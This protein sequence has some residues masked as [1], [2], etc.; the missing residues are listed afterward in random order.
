VLQLQ[1][2]SVPAQ[3]KSIFADAATECQNVA[4]EWETNASHFRN[5]GQP[6]QVADAINRFVPSV[7][8]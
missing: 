3:P 8:R 5:F 6:E 7:K 1:A 4:I 2:D